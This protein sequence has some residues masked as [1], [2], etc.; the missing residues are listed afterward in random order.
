MEIT[1]IIINSTLFEF[2][3]QF[4]VALSFSVFLILI[5]VFAIVYFSVGEEKGLSLFLVLAVFSLATFIALM[6]ICDTSGTIK[7]I[8]EYNYNDTQKTMTTKE[9]VDEI[10]SLNYFYKKKG[11]TSKVIIYVPEEKHD[12]PEESNNQKLIDKILELKNDIK[13]TNCEKIADEQEEIN[14]NLLNETHIINPKP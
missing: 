4:G 7:Y 3:Y 1:N 9:I 5:I 10:N 11:K 12:I 2:L 6:S 14:N 13:K 8:V